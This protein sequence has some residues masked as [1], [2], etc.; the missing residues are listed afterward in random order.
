MKVQVTYGVN[1]M[2]VLDV[3]SGGVTGKSSSGGGGD[4]G[5]ENSELSERTK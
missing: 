1:S 5:E 2:S 4:D 3:V